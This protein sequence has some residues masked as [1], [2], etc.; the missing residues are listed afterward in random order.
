MSNDPAVT[1]PSVGSAKALTRASGALM[2]QEP[3]DVDYW[4]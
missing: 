1:F 3:N 2:L 4:M